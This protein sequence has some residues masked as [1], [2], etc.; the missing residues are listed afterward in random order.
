LACW[1]E[2]NFLPLKNTH[3]GDAPRS[4]AT[5]PARVGVG[6]LLRLAL[7]KARRHCG[8]AVMRWIYSCSDGDVGDDASVRRGGFP[9]WAQ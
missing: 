5:V 4:D 2:K 8:A 1:L 3:F 6:G 7:R 9:Y